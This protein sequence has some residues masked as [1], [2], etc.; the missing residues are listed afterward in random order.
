M[1]GP[2]KLKTV[3]HAQTADDDSIDI[4]IETECGFY[5]PFE[6]ENL[7]VEPYEEIFVKL[8]E[9]S[10]FAECKKY[11]KHATC[12]VPTGILKAIEAEGKLALPTDASITFEKA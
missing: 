11:C 7:N 1:P 8:G 10:V 2:C 3:V 9:G 5:K 6:E 4:K 12:L